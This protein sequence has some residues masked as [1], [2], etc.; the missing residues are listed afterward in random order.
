M[1]LYEKVEYAFQVIIL[2]SSLAMEIVGVCILII[3][4]LKAVQ[5]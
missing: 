3:N 1:E 2:Y 4:A 5:A